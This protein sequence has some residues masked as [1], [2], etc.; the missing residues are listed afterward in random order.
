MWTEIK[1]EKDVEYFMEKTEIKNDW[2]PLEVIS[3]KYE[4]YN[5]SMIVECRTFGRLE[6]FFERVCHFSRIDYQNSN[7]T[8]CQ[9]SHMQIRTD[10]RGQVRHDKSLIVWTDNR[11]V[12]SREDILNSE[13]DKII[14]VAEEMKY[15]F[16]GVVENCDN[17]YSLKEI[18]EENYLVE[19]AWDY[20]R[21][22]LDDYIKFDEAE[23]YGITNRES[24]RPYF[25]C[26]GFKYF[27]DSEKTYVVM[28]IKF[29]DANNKY[30]GYYDIV[31]DKNLE[32]TDD[33]FVIE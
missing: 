18:V 15:R 22:N 8:Y 32:I 5:I 9:G 20:F 19:I 6:M 17:E 26:Y 24:V 28:T 29:N 1:T 23:K 33:F 21:K 11:S 3:L 31:F 4:K 10:L 13:S 25:S 14:I 27:P 16:I 30:L 2:E 12:K 7:Y